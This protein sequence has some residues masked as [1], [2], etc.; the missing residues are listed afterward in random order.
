M[1]KEK[2]SKIIG[3]EFLIGFTAGLVSFGIAAIIM[4]IVYAL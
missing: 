2:G 1:K 4:L 3:K